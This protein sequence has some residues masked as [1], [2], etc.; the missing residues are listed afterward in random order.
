MERVVILG[1]SGQVGGELKRL[2]PEGIYPDR[3]SVD[4]A[5]PESIDAFFSK[6]KADL[7]VNCAAYTKVDKAET[8]QE[9]ALQVNA[10]SVEKLSVYASKI[11][12][13]STDYVF[14]G[15]GFRPYVETDNLDPVNFY[16]S[17]KAEGEKLLIRANKNSSIIRTSWVY[18]DLGENFL[19]TMIKLA[20]QK[21]ELRVVYDQI[22]SPTYAYDLAKLVLDTCIYHCKLAPGTFHYSN[23]GVASWYDF[24]YE[25]FHQMGIG[26]KLVPILSRDYPTS[27]NRPHFSVLDKTKIKKELGIQIPNW[28]DSLEQCLKKIPK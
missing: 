27:A 9:L 14:N 28:K 24:A 15:K 8:E 11:I 5:R 3:T 20:K 16:G 17:S 6:V 26:C 18:S 2:F 19:K 23:E 1:G 10:A 22:G 25:I 13:F 21:E 12:H 7:I 4:L